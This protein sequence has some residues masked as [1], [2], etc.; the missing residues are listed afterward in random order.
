MNENNIPAR[1]SPQPVSLEVSAK[2]YPVNEDG[3][4]PQQRKAN[5]GAQ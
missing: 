3:N 4:L 2:V 5:K 1:A